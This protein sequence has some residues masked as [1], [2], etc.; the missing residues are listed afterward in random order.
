MKWTVIY[1]T[2]L[3][4]P[5]RKTFTSANRARSFA[6]M[7]AQTGAFEVYVLPA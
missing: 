2:N 4:G 1:Q 6:K 7:L 5:G 3:S